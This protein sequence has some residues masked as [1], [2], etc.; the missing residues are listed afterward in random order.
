MYVPET[1]NVANKRSK[2]LTLAMLVTADIYISPVIRRSLCT[3][4]S[5]QKF[6]MRKC[7][8]SFAIANNRNIT[9]RIYTGD[10]VT[11]QYTEIH[12]S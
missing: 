5:A 6:H 3:S 7:E 1:E 2:I 4:T 12:T 9:Y 10:V 8:V 11:L